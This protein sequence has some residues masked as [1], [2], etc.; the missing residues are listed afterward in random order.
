MSEKTISSVKPAMDYLARM[1]WACSRPTLYRHMQDGL[2][3]KPPWSAE[4]LDRYAGDHLK[5]AGAVMA[6]PP[7][8]PVT[9]HADPGRPPS[10][11]AEVLTARK[12]KIEIESELKQFELERARGRYIEFERHSEIVC[13]KFA[14]VKQ[15]AENW[16]FE[17]VPELIAACNGDQSRRWDVIEQYRLSFAK[18]MAR[19][20]TSL[21]I[22]VSNED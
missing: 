17:F 4:D 5:P 20:D 14:L 16:I 12:V 1:G 3:A 21:D 2:L 10:L 6:P 8:D 11:A 22:E 18:Y 7:A 9:T 19:L 15:A 13:Q